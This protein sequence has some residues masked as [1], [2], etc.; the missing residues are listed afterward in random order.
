MNGATGPARW[1]VAAMLL[2]LATALTVPEAT[3]G[4]GD[5][6]SAIVNGHRVRFRRKLVCDGYTSAGFAIVGSQVPHRLGQIISGV[7]V[8]CPGDIT[9]VPLLTN[10]QFCSISVTETAVKRA[11][12][13]KSWVGSNPDNATIQVE[14]TKFEGGRLEGTFSG[15]LQPLFG[16]TT[17]A[18]VAKGTFSVV[19][20]GDA[21]TNPAGVE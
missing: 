6:V 2:V 5:K 12:T 21:C 19:L 1:I 11:P 18:T 3:A 8:T 13:V 9:V 16:T 17:P 10:P 4:P 7:A 15:T 14:L 20:G